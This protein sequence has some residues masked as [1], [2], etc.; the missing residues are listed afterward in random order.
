MQDQTR[1]LCM[2]NINYTY[3][4]FNLIITGDDGSSSADAKI[5]LLLACDPAQLKDAIP[6]LHVTIEEHINFRSLTPRLNKHKIFTRGEMEYFMNDYHSN[7]DKVNKLIMWLPTKD[8]KGICNF[9][10]ALKE[11]EEHSGHLEIIKDLHIS[12]N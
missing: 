11:A 4:T 12:V 2:Y 6:T 8:D 3:I 1:Y 10:R 9:V 5:S 7:P